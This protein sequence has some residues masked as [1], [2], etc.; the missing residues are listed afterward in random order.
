MCRHDE[1]RQSDETFTALLVRLP[2][3]PD[4]EAY[5][6]AGDVTLWMRN[7]PSCQSTICK[8]VRQ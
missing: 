2:H 1:A 4:A 6:H 8:E 7:C 3:I 5:M